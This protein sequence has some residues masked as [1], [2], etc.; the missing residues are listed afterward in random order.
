MLLDAWLI[1]YSRRFI[2]VIVYGIGKR[3]LHKGGRV[4]VSHIFASD[5]GIFVDHS[6]FGGRASWGRHTVATLT[7]METGRCEL[8]PCPTR[9]LSI[10]CPSHGTHTAGTAV[11]ARFGVATIVAVKVLSDSGSGPISDIISGVN[12]A[13]NRF[14]SNRAPSVATMSLGGAKSD[15]LDSAVSTVNTIWS[16]R[17]TLVCRRPSLAVFTLPSPPV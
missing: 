3:I 4:V 17:L 11:G 9:C 7:L 16:R 13:Y 8:C 1:I 12:Y 14:Q 10:L 15:A 5:T 6:C 2:Q